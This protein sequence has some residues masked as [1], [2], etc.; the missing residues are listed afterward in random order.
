MGKPLPSFVNNSMKRLIKDGVTRPNNL[1]PGSRK[2]NK[3]RRGKEKRQVIVVRNP[4]TIATA[5]S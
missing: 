2:N 3:R 5:G 4:E 1:Q